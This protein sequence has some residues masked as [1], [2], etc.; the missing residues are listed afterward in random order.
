MVLRAE[1]DAADLAYAVMEGVGFGFCSMASTPCVRQAGRG[2]AGLPLPW[3]AVAR[4]T[5]GPSCWPAPGHAAAAPRVP[6]RR[7]TGRSPLAPWP[8]VAAEAHWCQ[9]W[10]PMPRF[11]QPASKALLAER[12]ARFVALCPALQAQ[13]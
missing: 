13:F 12:Y 2:D 3:S 4:A 10:R 8:A 1:H 7:R 11:S 9:P 5:P 6:R